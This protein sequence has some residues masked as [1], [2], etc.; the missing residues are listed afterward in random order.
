MQL[1][2]VAA[3][4]ILLTVQG[5]VCEPIELVPSVQAPVAVHELAST[6]SYTDPEDCSKSC[7]SGNMD[8]CNNLG[9]EL[10]VGVGVA[11]ELSAAR[12][13]YS[14]ACAAHVDVACVNLARLGSTV[15]TA[16]PG[17]TAVVP[18][19]TP[20]SR[21]LGDRE[22][23]ERTLS[24]VTRLRDLVEAS[25]RD[26]ERLG[27]GYRLDYASEAPEVDRY[28]AAEYS[29]MQREAV[30][31]HRELVSRLGDDRD[32]RG[33]RADAARRDDEIEEVADS[34]QSMAQELDWLGSTR[35]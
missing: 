17:P 24:L 3:T 26:K 19:P 13:Y 10:E 5:C 15:A 25:R 21:S 12:A 27:H 28:V 31:Y 9:A 14:L 11:R 4:L 7:S 30:L 35:K 2:Q 23:G 1:R 6:C 32:L 29:K 20:T 22:L 33:A 18:A 8:S 16:E 34:L